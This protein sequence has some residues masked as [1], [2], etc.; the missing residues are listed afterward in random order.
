[1]N[2]IKVII[3]GLHYYALATFFDTIGLSLFPNFIIIS[4]YVWWIVSAITIFLWIR[5]YYFKKKP[6][7][8][9]LHGLLIGALLGVFTFILEITLVVYG[10]GMGW[11]I[12]QF[13]ESYF[14]YTLVVLSPIIAALTK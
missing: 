9:L 12:Y 11:E 10:F 4:S 5:Y 1:L 2:F 7:N 3:I 6:K 13:W 14:Q 8:P